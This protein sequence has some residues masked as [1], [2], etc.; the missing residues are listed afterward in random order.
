[1]ENLLLPNHVQSVKALSDK[2]PSN[3]LNTQPEDKRIYVGSGEDVVY[4]RVG[5]TY[6][7]IQLA[8]TGWEQHGN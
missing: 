5:N 8:E 3:A 7:F 1:M 6:Q 2:Q 4:E